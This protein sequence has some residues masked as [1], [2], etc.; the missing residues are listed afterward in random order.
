MSK[1][2]TILGIDGSGKTALVHRLMATTKITQPSTT[3]INAPNYHESWDSPFKDLSAKLEIFSSLCDELQS[4]ELKGV[5]L[6]LQATL[7]GVIEQ[8]FINNWQ[9][10][11]ILSQ[12]HPVLDS[13][14]YGELYRQHVKENDTSTLSA[15]LLSKLQARQVPWDFILRWF[16]LH[17][18]R[19][20]S[21]SSIWNFSEEILKLF[22]LDWIRLTVEL[23]F[24]YQTKMPDG[25][26]YIHPEVETVLANI[27]RR[28]EES[29]SN[30]ELH[31]NLSGLRQLEKN[32]QKM[33]NFIKCNYS[34]VQIFEIP[35]YDNTQIDKIIQYLGNHL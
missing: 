18:Q 15:Q 21:Q 6:Y 23:Q 25:I 3:F 27:D 19:T 22:K 13:L 7:F 12:R 29:Q 20:K 5:A 11:I 32:Y 35:A 1:H 26:I 2:Y 16:E 8:F 17:K 4:F 34:H 33:L 10:A 28:A 24:R 31:E 14:V 30:K 9:P